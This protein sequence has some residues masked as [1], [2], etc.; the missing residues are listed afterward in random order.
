[1]I[2]PGKK[3]DRS[4]PGGIYEKSSGK[5]GDLSRSDVKGLDRG[6][7]ATFLFHF[8]GMVI[9]LQI[10]VLFR[11]YDLLLFGILEFLVGAG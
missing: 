11:P 1:M 3:T 4:V 6:Y 8:E 10:N 9:K 2:G 7:F 5:T